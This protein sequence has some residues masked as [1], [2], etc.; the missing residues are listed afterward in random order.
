M[1][2]QSF[3]ALIISTG[4][5][6]LVYKL[7]A[8]NLAPKL[9]TCSRQA[10]VNFLDQYYLSISLDNFYFIDSFYLTKIFGQIPWPLPYYLTSNG[11]IL[12]LKYLQNQLI[13]FTLL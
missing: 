7:A 8:Q 11:T 5:K 9:I 1:S 3:T 12:V 2:L 4:C 13:L 6:R 10:A